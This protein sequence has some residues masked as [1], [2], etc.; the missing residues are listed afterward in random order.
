MDLKQN[1]DKLKSQINKACMQ[2]GRRTEDITIVAA[3]KTRTAGEINKALELGIPAY[4][5]NRVQEL[6]EKFP[7]ITSSGQAFFIGQLQ[8]NK[9]K[10]IIDKVSLIQS[11]DRLSLAQEINRQALKHELIMP[12]LIEVNIGSEV[13]K[14]G[15]YPSVDTLKQFCD[16]LMDLPAVKLTGLMTVAPISAEPYE[17][18]ACFAKMYKLYKTFCGHMGLKEGILSMGMSED[19]FEAILEGSNMIRP[20]R[21]LFGDRK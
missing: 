13:S 12:V 7:D 8:S 3:S 16:S 14:G 20:G 19:Y 6:L 17:R 5:E 11:V 2:A 1:I 15:I 4:G 21:A 9:V 10:Y 18:R